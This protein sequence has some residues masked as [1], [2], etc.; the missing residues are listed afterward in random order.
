MLFLLPHWWQIEKTGCNRLKTFPLMVAQV[1]PQYR[2]ANILYLGL[3]KKDQTWKD[4]QNKLDKD[5]S[6]L[7]TINKTLFAFVTQG[8]HFGHKISLFEHI[9]SR[10][11]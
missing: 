10:Q 2:V 4:E 6:S 9:F 3:W 8:R 11:S 1:W 7:G 5:I